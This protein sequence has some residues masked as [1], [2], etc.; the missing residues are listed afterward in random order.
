MKLVGNPI[1]TD[2]PPPSVFFSTKFLYIASIWV[3]WKKFYGALNYRSIFARKL[4]QSLES[5]SSYF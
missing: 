3:G 5:F 4:F 2:P 1:G